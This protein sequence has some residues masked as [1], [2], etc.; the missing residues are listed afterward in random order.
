[1]ININSDATSLEDCYR[2]IA[3]NNRLLK[4]Y[5]AALEHA[6]I[7][8]EYGKQAYVSEPSKLGYTYSCLANCQEESGLYSEALQ[9][10]IKALEKFEAA[11]NDKAIERTKN[12]I[13]D[14]MPIIKE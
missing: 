7:A 9:N 13:N 14:I 4:C 1:M 8:L 5:D 2:L 12:R 3:I 10:Y 11:K 6:K